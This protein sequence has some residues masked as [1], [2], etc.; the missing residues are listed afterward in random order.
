MLVELGHRAKAAVLMRALRVSPLREKGKS[1][2]VLDDFFQAPFWKDFFP[3][4]L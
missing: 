3:E 2:F 1:L 4:V